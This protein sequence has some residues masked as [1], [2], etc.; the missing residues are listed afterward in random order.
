MSA[1]SILSKSAAGI[2]PGGV[3]ILF[4]AVTPRE[5]RARFWTIVESLVLTSV[6]TAPWYL[7]QGIVHP[8]WL[9]VDSV[10]T[11]L[12]NTGFH[13]DRNSS[14]GDLHIVYYLRRLFEI[15]PV[16]LTVALVSLA[17]VFQ[18]SRLRKQPA[19]LL[20]ACWAVVTVAALF[21][22]QAS[23]LP[24]VVLVLPSLCAAGVICGP[25]WL[26]RRPV[27]TAF[28]IGILF[29]VRLAGAGQ[30]WSLRTNAP[31][32]LGADAMRAYCNL[33][34]DTELISIDPDD[35]FYSLTIPL[36]HVRYCVLDPEDVLRRY[37]PHYALLGIV[38][39]SD[40]FVNLPRLVPQFKKQLLDWGVDS[41][42]P[43]GTTITMKVPNE[44]SEIVNA[45][46]ESDFYLPSRWLDLIVGPELTHQV[47]RY[48]SERTFLLSRNARARP[49]RISTIPARW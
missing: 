47:I 38:V 10:K 21:A 13:W 41:L 36:L 26:H 31:P 4:W 9:W 35:E 24:Y 11:Q 32:L 15:D 40:Q 37:A 34:R 46:P 14:I 49:G 16:I 12:I 17:G 5:R 7:Y 20:A 45:K 3:L 43:I 27:V 28:F 19:A 6:L 48:S 22:F 8:K 42:E 1:A 25:T 29:L 23:N 39:S 18:I 30:I 44:I 2:L 33:H